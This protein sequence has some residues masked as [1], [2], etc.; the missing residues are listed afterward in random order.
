MLL[1]VVVVLTRRLIFL[2]R[3]LV[4]DLIILMSNSK[5]V[6]ENFRL[7]PFCKKGEIKIRRRVAEGQA[8]KP[9]WE[10]VESNQLV[11]DMCGQVIHD[12]ELMERISL[13][14]DVEAKT[15]ICSSCH[16]KNTIIFQRGNFSLCKEC[17]ENVRE[18]RNLDKD[19]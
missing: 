18:E 1:T 13:S 17:L 7:C 12:N 2:G 9:S 11:C 6:T 19:I 3:G 8:N 5:T 14:V 4:Y 15:K 16:K 10:K